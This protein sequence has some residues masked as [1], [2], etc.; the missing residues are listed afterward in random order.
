MATQVTREQ[1]ERKKHQAAEFMERI[2]EPDRAEEFDSMSVDEYAD[3]RGLELVSNPKRKGRKT[4]MAT[5][6]ELQGQVDQAAAILNDAY[7]PESTRE[8]LATAVGDALDILNGEDEDPDEDESD[9][10]LDE[11][12]E[13]DEGE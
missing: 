4:T 9:A 10:E 12:D 13:E 1:A 11:E 2:G 3:H 6:S 7:T 5:K 8:E